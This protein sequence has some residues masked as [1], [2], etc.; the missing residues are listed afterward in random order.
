MFVGDSMTFGLGVGDKDA[1][2]AVVADELGSDDRGPAS[3]TNCG[4]PGYNLGQ[5][6]RASELRLPHAKPRLLVVVV[7][8]ADLE[9]PVDF[10]S[11]TPKGELTRFAMVHSRLIRLGFLVSRIHAIQGERQAASEL[12]SEAQINQYLDRLEAA[13]RG[14]GSRILVL[15]IGTIGHPRLVF[16]DLLT[17]RHLDVRVLPQLPRDAEHFL[18]DDE[19]WTTAGNRL[20]GK[21]VAAILKDGLL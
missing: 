2:P 10:S 9:T 4:V 1:F 21:Y 17:A 15:E 3:I 8:P 14:S 7:H 6:V 19:H 20:I 11:L 12:L 16:N 18:A 5:V 13:A